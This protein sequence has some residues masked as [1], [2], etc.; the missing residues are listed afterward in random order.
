[1]W[2]VL[3]ELEDFSECYFKRN[4]VRHIFDTLAPH[5]KHKHKQIHCDKAGTVTKTK[6]KKS[7]VITP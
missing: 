4:I 5:S 1:M 3:K 6:S 7:M 2:E